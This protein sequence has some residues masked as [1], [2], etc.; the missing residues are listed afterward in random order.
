M[1]NTKTQKILT[2]SKQKVRTSQTGFVN[3]AQWSY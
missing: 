3:D 1:A 2:I